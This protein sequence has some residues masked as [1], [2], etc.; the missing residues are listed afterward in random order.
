MR[1]SL[2]LCTSSTTILQSN[3]KITLWYPKKEIC[4]MP[5][6]KPQTSPSTACRHRFTVCCHR[7]IAAMNMSSSSLRYGPTH[8][9]FPCYKKWRINASLDII[10]RRR[11]PI[12]KLH[13]SLLSLIISVSLSMSFML[14]CVESS[15]HTNNHTLHGLILVLPQ[16]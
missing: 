16:L 1:L 13:M 10:S 14:Q 11:L 12:H 15:L 5:R 7:F 8:T 9:F 6:Y 4:W 2:L 3:S